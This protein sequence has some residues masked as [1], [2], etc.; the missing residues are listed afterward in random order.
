MSV[1]VRNLVKKYG[2]VQAVNDVS[3]SVPDGTMFA[4]LGEN[5][6]GKSTTIGCIITTLVPSSGAIEVDGFS[7]QHQ[8]SAVREHIGAVFQAS[9]LDARLSVAENLSLRGSFYGLSRQ[10]IKRK[11]GELSELVD[12]GGFLTQRYGTLSGGQKRRADIARA[13]IHEP[14][15]LFLDEPTAGLDPQSREQVWQG[16]AQLREENRITVFL[17]THYLEET[18]RA[19]QVC[20]IDHGSIVAE[21]TPTELRAQHSSSVLTFQ[22]QRSDD[23]AR[24]LSGR[25]LESF[26]RRDALAVP[27]QSSQ[28]AHE[29]LNTLTAQG[30]GPV[31][32]EFR[33]GTM[34][35]VFLAVTGKKKQ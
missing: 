21:G 23:I 16:I 33:H 32:F 12:L 1:I 6:A 2:Q 8:A 14:T 25:G 9:L 4:F 5:G 27:V 19:D 24:Y 13:L 28:Q 10:S 34:D 35:D 31:D 26:H 22:S 17:T 15:T 20:I 18:E 29:L 3:F 7:T 11:I 30:F